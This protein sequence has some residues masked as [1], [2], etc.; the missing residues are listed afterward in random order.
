MDTGS[1]LLFG[2]TLAGLAHVDPAIAQN[3]VLASAILTG[4]LIGSHAPDF[5]TVVRLKGF[6]SYVRF[7]RGVTHSVPALLIWPLI[8]SLPIA[9]LFHVMDDWSTL[10]LWSFIAVFFHV[11]LDSLNLYGVQSLRPFTKEWIH[12]DILAIFE[13]FLFFI[14]LLGTMLWIVYGINP[15]VLFTYVYVITFGYIGIR[16]VQHDLLMKKAMKAV[17]IK[18]VCHVFPS[19][20]WF[21]WKYVIETEDQ[22]LTGKIEYD[23]VI[24]EDTYRKDEKNPVIEATL[25]TDGVRAFLG[26]AQRIHVT[27][28]ELQDGYEVHWSDVRFWHNRHLAF[29]VDVHLDRDLNVVK[30]KF[31]WR[32]KVWELPFV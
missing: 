30:Q 23:K 18:G 3:P 15:G 9:F 5:D 31:G 1:H 4:T 13:P 27:Y 16:Y 19:F 8:I 20:H 25:K 6:S 12:L 26:F 21:H 28:K 32:K 29:G 10:Y 11:F 24:S 7:H 14:H 17:G 2:V 22:F